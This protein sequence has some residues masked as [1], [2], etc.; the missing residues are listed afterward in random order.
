MGKSVNKCCFIGNL[1][2]DPVVRYLPNGDA[3]CQFSLATGAEFKDKQTGNI[4]E[5]TEWHNIVAFKKKAEILGEYLKQGSK[6][7][8]EAKHRTRKYSDPNGV[9]RYWSEFVVL[10][11]TL[12]G[13]SRERQA[14]QPAQ[15]HSTPTNTQTAAQQPEQATGS[16]N[17]GLPDDVRNYL[18]SPPAP[19]DSFDDDIPF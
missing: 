18:S 8:I 6:V 13:N 4:V 16:A 14:A 2:D 11:F 15:S 10:D 1:G 17:A 5:S 3:V 7:Y 12:L 9:E 19:T